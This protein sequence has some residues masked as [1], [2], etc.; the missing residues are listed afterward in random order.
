MREAELA[1]GVAGEIAFHGKQVVG[2]QQADSDPWMHVSGEREPAKQEERADGVNDMIHVEAVPG[3]L[4]VAEAGQG[5]VE[6]VAKPVEREEDADEDERPGLNSCRPVGEA[7]SDHSD[8]TDHGKVVRIDAGWHVGSKPAKS[9]AFGGRQDAFQNASGG[10]ERSCLNHSCHHFLHRLMPEMRP[11]QR[12][13]AGRTMHR[14]SFWKEAFIIRQA[15]GTQCVTGR[16]KQGT[17]GARRWSK[18]NNP[19]FDCV[20]RPGLSRSD[21]MQATASS[22]D[23]VDTNGGGEVCP[24]APR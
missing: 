9:P 4:L 1:D 19:S 3:T 8:E 11:F 24:L 10:A 7:G 23:E 12:G 13:W 5:T 20:Q 22:F 21:V 17:L 6:A 14:R 15:F 16:G 2:E 18:R